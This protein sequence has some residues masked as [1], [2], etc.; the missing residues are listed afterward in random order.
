MKTRQEISDFLRDMVSTADPTKYPGMT[1]ENGVEEALLW[2]VGEIDDD[3][4]VPGLTI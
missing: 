2:V 3:D 4:F 1:Y